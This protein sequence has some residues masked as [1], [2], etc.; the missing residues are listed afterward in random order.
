[1]TGC[2]DNSRAVRVTLN[3]TTM[4]DTSMDSFYDMTTTKPVSIS[5][6]SSNSISVQFINNCPNT[7]DR[8]VASFYELNY[9]R[10][11]NFGGQPNFFFELP[12]KSAG[13]CLKI[14]NLAMSG[15]NTPVFYDLT[16]VQRYTAIVGPGSTLSVLLGRSA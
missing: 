5:L 12:A 11:F 3:G 9:P 7:E 13:Y 14:T 10:Q 16:E 4:V 6:L 8:T 2:A 15:G 1:M